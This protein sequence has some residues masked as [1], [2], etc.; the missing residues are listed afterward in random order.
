MWVMLMNKTV[1]AYMHVCVCVPTRPTRATPN[2]PR[3]AMTT[4]T[5][6]QLRGGVC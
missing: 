6:A 2:L 5:T 1:C 4:T 3:G